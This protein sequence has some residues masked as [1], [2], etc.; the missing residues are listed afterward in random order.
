M[1]RLFVQKAATGALIPASEDDSEALRR[2]KVGAVI[3]VEVKQVRNY[4]FHKKWF[5][6]VKF[7]F[8]QWSERPSAT[9]KGQPVQPNLD[10]F[11]R[12]LTILA[13]YSRVVVHVDG[14][15]RVEAESISFGR[16]NQETFEKL[17]SATI[18]IILCKILNGRGLTEEQ[19]RDVIDR[20]L[21]F[22]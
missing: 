4:E 17:Y 2:F 6:L 20:V 10:T 16:M 22:T 1:T 9:Y 18:N 11:R 14:S 5:A 3:S 13:G 19:L 21:Q 15:V 7:A 12:D 8:E